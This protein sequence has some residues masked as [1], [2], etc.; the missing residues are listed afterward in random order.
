MYLYRETNPDYL[1]SQLAASTSFVPNEKFRLCTLEIDFL[2]RKLCALLTL[3][4]VYLIHVI[5][6]YH[7]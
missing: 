3:L 6:L 7:F 4:Y 1:I 5:S 2:K